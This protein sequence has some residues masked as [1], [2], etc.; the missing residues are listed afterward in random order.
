MNL[1]DL[2]TVTSLTGAVNK[3]PTAPSK[4]SALGVFD[5]K[6]VTTTSVTID[7]YEGRLILVPNLSRDADPS[8]IKPGRRARRTFETLHLPL[9]RPLLPGQLQ[10]VAGFGSET[11]IANQAAI[12]NDHLSEMKN[13]IEATREYQR[14]GALR[15]RLLDAD[16]KV[17]EDLFDAFDVT[18]KKMNVAL[19]NAATDVRADCLKAKRHA[20]SKLNGVAVKGFAAFCGPDWFDAFTGHANVQKAFANY[21]EAQDR[22]GGDM[23]SGFTF[24]GITFIE[25]DATISGQRFIPVDVA[26][27]FPLAQGVFRTF[28][29]PANYNETVN[30][31]GKPFYSK[32]EERR[33]GKGWDIEVQANPLTLCMY[34]EAL[35]ELKAA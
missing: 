14:I 28:N 34:P 33:M 25:Y 31:L 24:G 2:F 26:Q 15:G 19:S 5:E 22:L 17:I 12:I 32:A 16:G 18:Q 29:A 4:A 13:S 3:L 35:V 6:G 11:P 10:N 21:Q 23:R 7:E 9:S 30:T 20:E 1:E 8:P 27:V